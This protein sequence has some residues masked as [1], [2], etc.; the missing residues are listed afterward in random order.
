MDQQVYLKGELKY[1][2]V[3]VKKLSFKLLLVFL[4]R[5][6]TKWSTHEQVEEISV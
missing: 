2:Y 1:L 4:I 5:P 6:E 3:G